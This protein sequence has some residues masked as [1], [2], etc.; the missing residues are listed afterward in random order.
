MAAKIVRHDH[1]WPTYFT[2]TSYIITDVGFMYHV[3]F[4]C[5]GNVI[6]IVRDNCWAP[7]PTH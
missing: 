3:M 5:S 7:R 1:V 6:T 4:T 2:G